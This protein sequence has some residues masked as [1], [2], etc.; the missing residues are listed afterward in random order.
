MLSAVLLLVSLQAAEAQAA[1]PEPRSGREIK[2]TSLPP[3]LTAESM[4]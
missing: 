2:M 4:R 3:S 1:N